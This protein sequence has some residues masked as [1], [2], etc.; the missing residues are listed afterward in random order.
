MKKRD[1][2]VLL[3]DVLGVI[4]GNFT[5]KIIIVIIKNL[6]AKFNAEEVIL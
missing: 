3:L 4:M 6:V 5:T 2:A 1:I